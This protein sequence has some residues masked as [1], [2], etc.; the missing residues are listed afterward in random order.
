M[1][2]T[3]LTDN[4]SV[5]GGTHKQVLR[6][7][8][9][10]RAS[11]D[12]VEIVTREYE[13]DACYEEFRG[14]AI[15]TDARPKRGRTAR[16]GRLASGRRL[17]HLI[18]RDTDLL[19]VHDQGCELITLQ[20][21]LERPS[22][23]VVWQ[24][25]DLHPA[26]RVGPYA[27]AVP[28]WIDP[29]ERSIGRYVARRCRAVTVNV[30]KNAV[31]VRENMGVEPQV[32]YCGVD[33]AAGRSISRPL[34][35]PLRIVSIGVLYTYRNYE[36]IIEALALLG[37]QGLPATLT[38]VGSAKYH[39]EYK[40]DLEALAAERQVELKFLGEIPEENLRRTLEESHVFVFINID[41]SWGLAAFEALNLSL[42]VV[43]SES[44]GAVELLRDNPS[45]T[46]VDPRSAATVAAAIAAIVSSQEAYD[47]LS[48]TAFG[49]VRNYT[50]EQLYSIPMRRLFQQVTTAP[51]LAVSCP[52]IN[53]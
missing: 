40:T 32:F 34:A 31:R 20:A 25:N 48:S 41:Q 26:Y 13:P 23:P 52:A 45:V 29:L 16:L 35:T 15:K 28:R 18:S 12:E 8:E 9:Y 24:I 47:R 21:L 1:K 7:A 50:W 17:S 39:P 6:L 37:K 22:L 19:N 44:V 2:I 36:T 33:Q 30:S 4:L 38:I 49:S 43:L 46:V 14:F 51:Q 3:L 53:V 42:P 5:R 27:G 11:G 10:L